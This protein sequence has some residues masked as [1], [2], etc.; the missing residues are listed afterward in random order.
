M[1]C[2][3]RAVIASVC[4]VEEAEKFR[5]IDAIDKQEKM[6]RFVFRGFRR[7]IWPIRVGGDPRKKGDMDIDMHV[8]ANTVLLGWHI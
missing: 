7:H 4:S 8:M 2:L 3:G 1:I 6:P 5:D